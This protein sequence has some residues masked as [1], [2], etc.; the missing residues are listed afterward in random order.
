MEYG[1]G[2]IFGCPAHDQRDLDFANEYNLEVVTVVKPSNYGLKKF[3]VRNTAF[4]ENGEVIN[5]DF[6]N[7]LKSEAAK[8]KIINLLEEKKIGQKKINYKLRDWGISRQRFWGCPIPVIYREDGELKT[9][10]ET[11]LPVKLP[12]V[13]NFGESSS[14]LDNIADWK[15]TCKK[16]E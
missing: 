15:E 14:A 6:L 7:G 9:V 10:E 3:Q 8:E 5:S 16:L 12:E 1:L 4:T 2:A 11:S 13:E